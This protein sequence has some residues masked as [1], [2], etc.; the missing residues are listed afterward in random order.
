M[1]DCDK[2]S[3]LDKNTELSKKINTVLYL[4]LRSDAEHDG[5]ALNLLADP[6]SYSHLWPQAVGSDQTN[7]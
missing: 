2:T 4:S 5:K 1:Q 6:C 3:S 7:I